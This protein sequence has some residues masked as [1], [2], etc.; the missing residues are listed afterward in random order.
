[1]GADELKAL[2]MRVAELE[3]R[4]RGMTVTEEDLAGYRKVAGALAIVP[5]NACWGHYV[6]LPIFFRGGGGPVEGEGVFVRL[7]VEELKGNQER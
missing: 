6:C 2:E 5:H 3:D 1:M 4:L 7:G